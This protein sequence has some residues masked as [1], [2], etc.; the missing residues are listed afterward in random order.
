MAQSEAK[1]ETTEGLTLDEVT[2]DK[3]NVDFHDRVG[4]VS[5]NIFRGGVVRG[6]KGL[7]VEGE[8][9]GVAQTRCLIEMGG[10]VEIENSTTS[11]KVTARNITIRGDVEGCQLSAQEDVEVHG[12]LTDTEIVV[13]THT[14][15][16]R[17][18]NQLRLE[19]NAVDVKI[20][21]IGVQVSSAGRKFIRDYPQ[22]ELKM[23]NI[24]VP[25]T[26]ELRVNLQQFYSAIDSADVE[27]I[28]HALKEFYLRVVV[29]MLTRNNK[30]YIS[31]NPNRHKVF[32]RL[33]EDLREHVFKV[34]EL[35]VLKERLKSSRVEALE[36]QNALQDPE[37]PTRLRV[38]GVLGEGVVIQ[39]VVLEDFVEKSGGTIDVQ[40]SVLECSVVPSEEGE[41]IAL[42]IK[43]ASGDENIV[44]GT[45]ANG[46]LYAG[47]DTVIWQAGD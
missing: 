23:G 2:M 13:G 14:G 39:F 36:I 45:F 3:G 43:D 7:T 46:S 29:G 12:S 42:K 44:E 9:L 34:R 6:S 32:L 27:K 24:L 21:E 15:N 22:V 4:I 16:I 1:M 41:G 37:E 28:D 30:N 8:V 10:D 19:Q 38:G 26:R 11:A 17:R 5:G 33:I 31:R 35:D 18:L 47:F 25:G 40:K 20:K